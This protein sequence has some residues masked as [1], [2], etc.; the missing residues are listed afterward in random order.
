MGALGRFWA[1]LVSYGLYKGPTI[2]ANF[3][4]LIKKL[5]ANVSVSAFYMVI[6]GQ[7]ETECGKN[8]SIWQKIDIIA[9]LDP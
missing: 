2:W 6:L 4:L 5:P 7:M 1:L 8:R 9:F 3:H